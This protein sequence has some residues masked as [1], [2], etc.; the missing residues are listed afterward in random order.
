MK[1][2]KSQEGIT[3]KTIIIIVAIIIVGIIIISASSK[4][5]Y[6]LNVRDKEAVAYASLR[7]A[8]ASSAVYGSATMSSE[9]FEILGKMVKNADSSNQWFNQTG[10]VAIYG[11][12]AD[13]SDYEIT[14]VSDGVYCAVFYVKKD[15]DT[16]YLTSYSFSVDDVKGHVIF[17][18]E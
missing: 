2:L 14:W 8:I 15:V 11:N 4:P 3:L 1:N 12:T 6:E 13:T 18:G 7:A 17:V 5:G 9:Y 10:R 16:Y